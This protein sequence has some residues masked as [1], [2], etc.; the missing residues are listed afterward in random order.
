MPVEP[1]PFVQDVAPE[2]AVAITQ[3]IY[4]VASF[5]AVYLIGRVVVRPLFD[6]V[7]KRRNL[8]THARKPLQ[9]VVNIAIVF[10]AIAVAFGFAEYGNFLT[11][12][13]TI[14]A[15]ATLAIGFAMQDVIANFVSGVFIYTD[16]PFR[17]GDWIEWDDNAGIV[18]D[19]S[20]RVT[21]VRTFDNELLTVPNS[22][23]TGGVIKNPVAKD[24]LRL[25]FLFGIGYDDDID[26]ATDII[27]EEAEKI[28]GILDDP[29]VSVRLTEL[30]NSYV[31][32]KSRFWISDPSR[33]DYVKIRADYVQAV[34]ERFDEEGIDIPY[35][36]R[37][38]E[39]EIEVAGSPGAEHLDE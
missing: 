10:V 26:K 30:G 22:V 21:R 14:A 31:G 35:P 18:E 16:E 20:L 8:D 1:L 17:I 9:K 23:L 25:Q 34:K 27:V 7:L 5:L 29:G 13:A 38:L 6:R 3:L 11:S 36:T 28:D 15:A 39:G 37:T 4:F 33:S 32:L 19:I 2:Y 24:R 12:L